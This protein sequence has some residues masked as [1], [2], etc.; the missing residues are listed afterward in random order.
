MSGV[1]NL[2]IFAWIIS[3]GN[4]RRRKDSHHFEWLLPINPDLMQEAG[5]NED[6]YAWLQPG[7]LLSS[8]NSSF[9]REGIQNLFLGLMG[10]SRRQRASGKL[11][12]TEDQVFSLTVLRA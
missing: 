4:H 5:G 8:D 3:P 9:T 1:A 7:L 11:S 2:L 12:Q 10:M 6:C